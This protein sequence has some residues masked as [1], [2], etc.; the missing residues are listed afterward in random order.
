MM[1]RARTRTYSPQLI[2]DGKMKINE[3]FYAGNYSIYQNIMFQ[4]YYDEINMRQG[5]AGQNIGEMPK[6]K[7]HARGGKK[8]VEIMVKAFRCTIRRTMV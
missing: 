5:Q 3:L 4:T 6:W 2:F 7:C 1:F 8:R